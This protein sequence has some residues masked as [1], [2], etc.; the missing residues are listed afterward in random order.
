MR[1]IASM[2]GVA[3]TLLSTIAA[4][5]NLSVGEVGSFHVGGQAL[6]LW[7]CRSRSWCSRRALRRSAWIPTATSNRA[8][9]V[10]YIKLG[11]PKARYPLLLWHGGGLTGVT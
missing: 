3:T 8:D 7:G 6:K 10:Q 2:L 11:Q 9:V 5:D 4:A 1:L